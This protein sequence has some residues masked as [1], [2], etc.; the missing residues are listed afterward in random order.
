MSYQNSR[1]YQR[2]K[3]VVIIMAL[4]IV[5]LVAAMAY[6]MMGRLSRDT[7]QTT[8]LVRE[9]QAEFYAEGSIAW[10]RDRLRND[11]IQQK[12]DSVIDAIPI[13]SPVKEVDGYTISSTIYDL[14]SRFNLNNLSDTKNQAIF[15]RLI[16]LAL[17]SVTQEQTTEIARATAD[18][19]TLSTGEN[20]YTKYYLDLRQ[21]N[22]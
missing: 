16:K 10:A 8:L 17:P 18:W 9:V 5:A 15:Q 2:Q 20:E 1:I 19:I 7:R 22:D 6:T 11:M 13:Q 4:F 21:P 14:Q 12:P 3:G